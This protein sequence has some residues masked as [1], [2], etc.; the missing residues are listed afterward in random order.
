[1]AIPALI[2]FGY[3]QVRTQRIVND[4]TESSMNL[5]NLVVANRDKIKD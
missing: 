3:F 2:A 4:M 5:M 1:V